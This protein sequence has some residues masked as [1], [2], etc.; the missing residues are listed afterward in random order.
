[1]K[2][3]RIGVVRALLASVAMAG[4]TVM[5]LLWMDP[6]AVVVERPSRVSVPEESFT[7]NSQ[8]TTSRTVEQ[9]PFVVPFAMTRPLLNTV[10]SR[11]RP[12]LSKEASASYQARMNAARE[13]ASP[14]TCEEVQAFCAFLYQSPDEAGLSAAELNALKNHLVNVLKTEAN[15]VITVVRHL[16]T[17]YCDKSQHPVWREYCLQ[18]LGTLYDRAKMHQPGIANLIGEALTEEGGSLA[19]TALIAMRR[20]RGAPPFTSSVIADSA[21]E[22]AE[23]SAYSSASRTTALQIAAQEND[24]RALTL[25]RT[26]L[27]GKTDVHLQVSALGVLGRMG[28]EADRAILNKLSSSSDVRLRGAARAAGKI[29]QSRS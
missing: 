25:A 11:L 13:L 22:V 24:P 18:H 3:T 10:P 23:S 26:L 16:M 21:M 28:D 20:N 19:G 7:E 1:M 15:D 5:L 29:V 17:L 14:L 27:R 2:M 9:N 12:L 6:E 4:V 8:P